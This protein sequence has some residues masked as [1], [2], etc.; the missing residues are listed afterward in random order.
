[1]ATFRV[2]AEGTPHGKGRFVAVL[3]E[4]Q[5]LI[6]LRA[7]IGICWQQGCL[8]SEV[9]EDGVGFGEKAAVLELDG[10]HLAN[11]ILG[12]KVV[13]AGRAVERGNGDRPVST[14]KM[15]ERETH[16]VAVA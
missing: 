13:F 14:A 16:F 9:Q 4:E 2:H 8:L 1:M 15:R 10:G 3:F 5:P 6:H 7:R 11:G 12:E